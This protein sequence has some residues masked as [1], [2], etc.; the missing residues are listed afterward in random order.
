MKMRKYNQLRMNRSAPQFIFQVP[1]AYMHV[2]SITYK[3]KKQANGECVVFCS[4]FSCS[5]RPYC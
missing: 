2:G 1:N 3:Y 4:S 5:Y